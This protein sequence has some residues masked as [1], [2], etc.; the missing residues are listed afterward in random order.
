M[1]EY[2]GTIGMKELELSFAFLT[3]TAFVYAEK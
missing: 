3:E 1:K 2:Q